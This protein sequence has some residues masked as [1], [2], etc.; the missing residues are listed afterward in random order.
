[1][2]DVASIDRVVVVVPVGTLEGA[3]SRL[4]GTLDAEERR[5][6]PS[7]SRGG[8]SRPPSRRRASPRCSS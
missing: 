7:A 2:T 8:R 5:D 4:G 3:K 1:M 6:P